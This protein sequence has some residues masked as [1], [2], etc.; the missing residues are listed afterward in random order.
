MKLICNNSRKRESALVG[1]LAF[2][3][4]VVARTEMGSAMRLRQCGIAQVCRCPNRHEKA[5][6][7]DPGGL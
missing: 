2:Q 5:A 1:A 6:G 4:H 3:L 7:F